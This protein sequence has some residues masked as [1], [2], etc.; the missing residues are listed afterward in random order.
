MNETTKAR[1]KR[2]DL[3]TL[4]AEVSGKILDQRIIIA[5]AGPPGSGK[6]TTAD[7]L[8]AIL[9][10]KYDISTQIVPMD[11]FHYDDAVLQQ[12]G[13]HD[14]KGAPETFDAPGL[15]ITLDRLANAYQTEEVAIPLFDRSLELSRG[16]ARIIQRQTQALVVEGNYLL[17][18]MPPWSTLHPYLGLTVMID[19]DHQTLR[20][21]LLK[22]WDDLGYTQD[23]A[24]KK[25]DHNDLPNAQQVISNSRVS[26]FVLSFEQ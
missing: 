24:I 12:L 11:G 21:R 10:K 22:R 25:V 3:D 4:G 17:M 13:I 15:T 8:E 23:E 2:I 6:S 19:C 1:G 7:L 18:D 20:T 14:R 9:R 26:D 16:S 5:I